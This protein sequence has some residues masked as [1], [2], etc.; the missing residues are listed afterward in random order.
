MKRLKVYDI[1]II[2]LIL[3][4]IILIAFFTL[5]PNSFDDHK[6]RLSPQ[7]RIKIKLVTPRY[8]SNISVE[9]ALKT[10]RSIRRYR[11]EPLT[12]QEVGQLLWSAQGITTLNGH[13]AAPSAGAIYPLE[14][15]VS[16]GKVTD[17][18]AGLYHYLPAEHAL[19]LVDKDDLREKIA[20]VALGQE[21]VRNGAALIIITAD[22][23][24]NTERYGSRGRQYIFMEA[25]HVAENVYLQCVSLK[26]GTVAVGAFSDLELKRVLNTPHDP[27]YLLPIGKI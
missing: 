3:I 6:P 25:G 18:P 14:V 5:I 20:N 9:E 8:T 7:E 24:R 19:E 17:L 2:F 1:F 21:S 16:S 22:F 27:V 26:L 11:D 13:R 23:R 4:I 12:L 15:Y 10:R